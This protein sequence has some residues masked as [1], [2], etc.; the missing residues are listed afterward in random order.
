MALF[1]NSLL[2]DLFQN[3]VDF[4]AKQVSRVLDSIYG[5]QATETDTI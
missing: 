5:E 4:V 1:P 3:N 2:R